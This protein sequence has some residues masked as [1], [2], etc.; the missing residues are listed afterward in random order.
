M[1]DC[2]VRREELLRGGT[3]DDDILLTLVSDVKDIKDL[4]SKQKENVRNQC[5]YLRN[6]YELAI[7]HMNKITWKKCCKLAIDELEDDGIIF[8]EK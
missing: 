5:L 4:S 2:L 8:C 1:I 6:S 7:Q 3:F